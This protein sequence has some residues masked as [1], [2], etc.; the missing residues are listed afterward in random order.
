MF[1]LSIQNNQPAD[2]SFHTI[3]E[4]G[5]I[6]A[7]HRNTIQKFVHALQ[8]IGCLHIHLPYSKVWV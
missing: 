8:M 3:Y 6:D 7:G 4:I 1:A 2:N 5:I